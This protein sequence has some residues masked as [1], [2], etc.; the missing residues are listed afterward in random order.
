MSVLRRLASAK[1]R[2]DEAPNKELAKDLA[3]RKD[4]A[5]IGELAANLKSPDPEIR[6]D[7]VKVL[8]ETG[9]LD[10]ELIADYAEEFLGLLGSKNNRMVWGGMTALATIAQQ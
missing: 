7:C 10:P 3:K 1:A 8:Y 9:A 2:R 6:S 4:R 5:A